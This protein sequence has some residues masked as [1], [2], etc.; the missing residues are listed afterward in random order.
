MIRGDQLVDEILSATGIDLENHYAFR[1]PNTVRVAD[2]IIAGREVEIQALID[3]HVPDPLY[4]P[5]DLVQLIEAGA[6]TQASAIPGWAHWIEAEALAWFT[7]N[8]TDPL[9]TVPNVDGL[10]V[11]VYRANAQAIDAQW[12]D[13]I[14]AQA[15]AIRG[16][17]RMVLAMRNRLWPNLEGSE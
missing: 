12:Q 9:V 6:E 1:P 15:A 8:I 5:A 16:L 13:I 4:F 17:A 14:T 2:A 10:S 7:E 3:I 11:D